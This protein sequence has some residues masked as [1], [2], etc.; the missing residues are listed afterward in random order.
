MVLNTAFHAPRESSNES[1]AGAEIS[2]DKCEENN[3]VN[4]LPGPK[5]GSL[6]GDEHEKF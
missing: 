6:D 1:I 4:L 2:T 5:C 3:S